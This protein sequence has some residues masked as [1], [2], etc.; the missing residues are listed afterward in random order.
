VSKQPPDKKIAEASIDHLYRIFTAPEEPDSTLARLDR[1]ISANLQGFLQEKIVASDRQ[2][3]DLEGDFADS[4]IPEQPTF[5]SDHVEFLLDKLVAESVHTAAPGFVGH[6]TSAFPYFMLPLS[7]IMVALNQ[8]V[9]K[10]ETSKAFTPMERQVIAMMHRLVYGRDEAF[11]RSSMHN[12]EQAL[13]S[14]CSGGTIANLTALWTAR[15]NLL[16]PKPGPAW[17]ACISSQVGCAMKCSFCA[18]GLM[19]LSRNLN[20]EEISDQVLFWRQ[21]LREHKFP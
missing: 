4:L 5:V 19:G 6:M 13:G 18:T 11:Y 14:F 7:R 1:E 17:S 9:V 3:T 15:N 16:K 12:A 10:T 2:L 8:N 20:P 21:Y